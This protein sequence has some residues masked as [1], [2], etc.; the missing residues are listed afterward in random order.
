MRQGTLDLFLVGSPTA[1]TAPFDSCALLQAFVSIEPP[2]HVRVFVIG[3]KEAIEA[4][5]SG[6]HGAEYNKPGSW[7]FPSG[8]AWS[9]PVLLKPGEGLSQLSQTPVIHTSTLA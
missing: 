1:W 5:S 6:Q 4:A 8:F 3:G 7:Q 2:E 9:L